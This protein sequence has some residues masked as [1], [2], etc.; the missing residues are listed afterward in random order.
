MATNTQRKLLCIFAHPD[1]EV[2]CTGGT[3]AQAVA[4]GVEV[5]VV[6]AT[7]GGAG[8]INDATVATRRTLGARRAQEL[9][10]SCRELGAQHVQCL[11]YG[12][13]T[14]KDLE[15]T[16]LVE[17]VTRIIRDFRPDVVIS[18]GPDGGYGH[19]D[20]VTISHATTI[21]CTLS[22]SADEFPQQG[23]EPHAPAALYHAYFPPKPILMLDRLSE[24][25]EAAGGGRAGVG[26][27][28]QDVTEFVRALLVF[29]EETT[30]LQYSQD[31]MDIKWFPK[32]FY[33]IEQGEVARDL[34]LI[35]SG[36]AEA[37][38]E[39]EDGE[40]KVLGK[41]GPGHFFGE[42]GIA[43]R[44]TRSNHVVARENVTCLVL[45]NAE[46]SAFTGRG[47][48]AAITGGEERLAKLMESNL[49]DRPSY[50]AAID[51]SA[52]IQHKV[53]AMA[54]HRTQYPISPNLIPASILIDLMG[55][56][57]FTQVIPP[58]QIAK[59]LFG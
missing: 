9:H 44:A 3:I 16:V 29:A 53:A 30:L 6:S 55:H 28:V 21:A 34:Y 51:V 39:E 49:L 8:Q 37:V 35:M 25:L 15:L 2:F 33:I 57:Y 22:G 13:G 59:D 17:H 40:L 24:W 4:D 36:S 42:M 45:S 10:D 43:R 11:D 7:D 12:D 46:Q 23:L 18:F 5:M 41:L 52:F 14:L 26:D 47:S 31:R 38:H 48:A 19:P 54:A 20:H 27:Q 1:D 58:P 50:T 56:E 32:G